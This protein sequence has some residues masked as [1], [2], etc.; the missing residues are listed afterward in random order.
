MLQA[1]LRAVLGAH[2]TQ[3]GSNI[4][5]ERL[6]FDF[7]H[8]DKMTPDQ[9]KAVEDMVNVKIQEDLPVKKQVVEWEEGQRMGAIGVLEGK[10]GQMVSIYTIPGFSIEFCGG[11]HVARTGE[12]G[13]FKILKE[14]SVASGIRR[15]KATA[16]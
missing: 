16:E 10:P 1:S 7:S 2:V 4:T 8:P 3:K 14:E 13:K 5:A 15:I 6:R 12:L 11:P 9:I